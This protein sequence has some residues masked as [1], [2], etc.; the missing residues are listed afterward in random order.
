MVISWVVYGWL[1]GVFLQK[2]ERI[3]IFRS[4]FAPVADPAGSLAV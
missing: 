4:F 2:I 3:D 1:L